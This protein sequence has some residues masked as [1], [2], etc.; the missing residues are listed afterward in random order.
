VSKVT[1]VLT[2]RRP[3]AIN[4]QTTLVALGYK[5]F[6]SRLVVDV[7]ADQM[8]DDAREAIHC[9]AVIRRDAKLGLLPI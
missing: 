9:Q 8:S 3:R 2:D 6:W 5:A 1:Q 7:D 4:D